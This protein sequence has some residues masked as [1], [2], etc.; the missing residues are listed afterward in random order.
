MRLTTLVLLMATA[1]VPTAAQAGASA[2]ADL[3]TQQ[4][5]AGGVDLSLPSPEGD[6]TEVGDRLRT[7]L[8][9]LMTP[10][11]NRLLAAYLSSKTKEQL[12]NGTA[13]SGLGVAR[14]AP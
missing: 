10:S 3:V 12:L 5:K 11:T 9:D 2:K 8:F 4:A 1:I 13:S 7:Q 14:N 6:F